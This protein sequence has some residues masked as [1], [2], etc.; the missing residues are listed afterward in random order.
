M[1]GAAGSIRRDEVTRWKDGHVSRSDSIEVG[2]VPPFENLTAG[3]ADR[4]SMVEFSVA[5]G[6]D[7]IG[8][9]DHVSFRDGQ[10]Y[11]GLIH[12]ASVLSL[13]A[14][15]R[16]FLGVYLLPLRHP[17][18]V[19]RQLATISEL[20]PGRF[21]LAVGI[22]GEDRMEVVNCGV[23]P[24]TRGKRMDECLET[25]HLLLAGDPVSFRGEFIELR[26]AV[27]KPPPSPAIPILVGGRSEAAHMRAASMG[28][29]WL[30]LWVSAGRFASVIDR[31]REEASRLDRAD[32]VDQF[33]MSVWTGFGDNTEDARRHIAEGMRATYHLDF[34]NFEKWSPY[35]TPER[36]AEFLAPYVEA[37]CR[38]FN[39]MPRGSDIET[40]VECVSEVRRL[41]N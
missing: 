26:D 17:T 24:A 13:H 38:T 40:I 28:N 33:A 4:R 22:G 2:F 37:G 10:G 25:L 6:V 3:L 12:A 5:H 9:V 36:V 30:G 11:D 23:D 16:V 15:V 34:D 35:G 7:H 14:D 18:T 20:A 29:G 39:L 8:L 41:L 19:S 32:E 1:Q 27:I 31:I 21:T